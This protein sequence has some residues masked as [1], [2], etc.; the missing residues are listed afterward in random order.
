MQI[1]PTA[2]ESIKPLLRPRQ[3]TELQNDIKIAEAKLDAK[4][5]EDKKEA[6]RQLQ[7]LRQSYN[8]Q[9]PK[10][11]ANGE[12]EGK[13][14]ARADELLSYIQE[15]MLSAAEMRACPPGAPDRHLKWER[16]KKA[17]ILEWK[18]LMLR[19]K[20]GESEAA[21]LE[22]YRPQA[23][24][25]NLDNAFVTRKQ[26][27]G[28]ENV[29]EPTITFN[30]EELRAIQALDP[31]THASIGLLDNEARK[32]VKRIISGLVGKTKPADQKAGKK[33]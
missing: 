19:L 23:S 3:V 15:G 6:R 17:A 14:V 20:P 12:E 26:F 24:S 7:R 28:L 16:E 1:A 25:M 29:G 18:G 2:P 33:N 13:M 31:E 30:E 8:E 4:G 22:R 10:P 21:N 5:I 27:Y 11:P 9:V 32:A